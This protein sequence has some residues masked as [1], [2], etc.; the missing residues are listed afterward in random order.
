MA[1]YSLLPSKLSNVKLSDVIFIKEDINSS[2][3]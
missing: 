3:S 1:G 2:A